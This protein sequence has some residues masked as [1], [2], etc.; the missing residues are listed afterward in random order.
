MKIKKIRL[1]MYG[2]SYFK[3]AIFVGVTCSILFVLVSGVT[4]RRLRLVNLD[5]AAKIFWIFMLFKFLL[6][7][8][9]DMI[10][11]AMLK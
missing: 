2:D 4:V 3:A 1:K 11:I 9:Q 10:Y 5:R 7:F 8:A 6:T